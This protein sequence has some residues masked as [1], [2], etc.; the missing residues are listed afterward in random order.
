MAF[1]SLT[2]RLQ[3]AMSKLRRKGKVTE[4]DKCSRA[5]SWGRSFRKL[6]PSATSCENR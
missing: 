5:G 3:D 4:D 6:I 1:E 2:K